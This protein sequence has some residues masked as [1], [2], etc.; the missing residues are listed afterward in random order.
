MS[1]L[2]NRKCTYDQKEKS[3]GQPFGKETQMKHFETGIT[4]KKQKERQKA[5]RNAKFFG[6]LEN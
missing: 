5:H 3:D 4:V 1:R 2:V 6:K